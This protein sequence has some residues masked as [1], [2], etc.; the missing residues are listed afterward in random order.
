MD[1]ADALEDGE[2]R[3]LETRLF[4]LQ[5]FLMLGVILCP[6]STSEKA[7][8]YYRLIQEA[9]LEEVE[10]YDSELDKTF[11]AALDISTHTLIRVREMFKGGEHDT[12]SEDDETARQ[13]NEALDALDKDSIEDMLDIYKDEVFGD[14]PRLGMV[15]FNESMAG[16]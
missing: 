8:V 7:K 11:R 6:G 4:D 1:L 14:R 2:E 12:E 15:E 9:M 10:S 3:L 13:R 16:Q 5:T